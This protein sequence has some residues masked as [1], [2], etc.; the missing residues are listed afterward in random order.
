MG[1]FKTYDVRGIYGEEIDLDVAY[2]IGRG[3]AEYL[4]S[5]RYMVGYDARLHSKEMYEAVIDGIRDAGGNVTGIGLASTPQLHFSQIKYGY[6]GGIMVTASHNPP[7]YHGFKFYDSSGGSVSYSK[8]LKE[9]ERIVLE[10]FQN[11]NRRAGR[12]K[13]ISRGDY[14]ERD[15]LNEYLD[16]ICEH[17]SF[18]NYP[19]KFVVD[20]S[21]GSSGRV[22]TGLIKKLNLN[23]S[24]INMEPDGNFPN[25]SPNPLKADSSIQL[26]RRVIEEKADFGAILDGDGDRVLFVD[27][28]GEKIE[29]YFLSALIA[30]ELLKEHRG[31]S[32]VYDLIASR[33]LPER[34]SELGGNPVVSRVGYTFVY[35]RMVET[36]ALFGS[37]TSGHVYFKVTDNYYTESAAYALIVVLNLVAK[38]GKKISE[39]VEPLK[40][41]YYQSGEINIEIE[42]KQKALSL[43]ATHYKEG[44]I[45]RLD[46]VSVEFPDFWFNVR[47]SNTEPVL[48]IRLE[49]KDKTVVEKVKEELLSLLGG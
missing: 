11:I 35:D 6:G 30:E 8:G 7:E 37:E 31:A 40:V 24:V 36:K 48:R 27:E 29:N 42:D 21:N 5:V 2:R 39:L 3:F 23:G 4:N 13:I 12:E 26:S 15:T 28:K 45:S 14:D 34:I 18:K 17:A 49:G 9:V 19:V 32:I 22:F 16:F 47:P 20:V 46:G 1:I 33:A 10:R 41:K 38:M 44:K 25:H 43:I